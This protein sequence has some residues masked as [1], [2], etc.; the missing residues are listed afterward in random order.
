MNSDIGLRKK[1]GN[2]LKENENLSNYSWFNLG[3]RAEYFYKANNI[4]E[5]IKFLGEVEKKIK[6]AN[7]RSRL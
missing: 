1:F 5:L 6:N 4:N 2:N 3:G 7:N